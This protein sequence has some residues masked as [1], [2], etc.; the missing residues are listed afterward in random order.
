MI[1][2]IYVFGKP[3]ENVILYRGSLQIIQEQHEFEGE[4]CIYLSWFPYPKLRFKLSIQAPWTT[5]F[6]LIC[7][8]EA[9]IK[10]IVG[11]EKSIKV[12]IDD[13]IVER[14]NTQITGSIREEILVGQDKPCSYLRFH[15][16]NLDNRPD[17]SEVKLNS[18]NWEITIRN[19]R[20][21]SENLKIVEKQGGYAI[22]DLG[23]VERTDGLPFSLNDASDLIEAIY[24][25]LSFTQGF[26]VQPFLIVG[27]DENDQIL[28]EKWA[29]CK[30]S[31][32]KKSP[33]WSWRVSMQSI[34]STFS[35]F[36][37][38]WNNVSFKEDFKLSISWYLE[39]L[40]QADAIEGGIIF[41]QAALELLASKLL[42]SRGENESKW[43]WQNISKV[44][45]DQNI[46][47]AISPDL[48]ILTECSNSYIDYLI[49]NNK[50]WAK[51]Q[52]KS[53][54]ENGVFILTQVRNSIVHPDSDDL[55][56]VCAQNYTRLKIEAWLLG[57][58]YIE[59]ILLSLF[60]YKG[61]YFNR[62][63]EDLKTEIIPYQK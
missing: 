16:T 22:T 61:K 5:I 45:K 49:A 51:E 20:T 53:L 42:K 50:A 63:G 3:N 35:H 58:Y 33:S 48:A 43:A 9:H 25:Y 55:E 27:Y 21:K 59:L 12:L 39:S 4:G 2:P 38:R 23:Q 41:E 44:L 11:V 7:T 8:S 47:R 17:S 13:S 56:T 62:L 24:Y 14:G 40:K 26:R 6:Y 32:Y 29:S 57:I 28:W 31:S 34:A 60:E 10:K 54:R 18:E 36:L 15:L 1:E 52:E 46:P 37:D 19:I 30:S